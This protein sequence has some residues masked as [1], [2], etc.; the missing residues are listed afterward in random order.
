MYGKLYFENNMQNQMY[1][2]NPTNEYY[3]YIKH[4]ESVNQ[5]RNYSCEASFAILYLFLLFKIV[6]FG[7][8]AINYTN[9]WDFINK[10]NIKIYPKKNNNTNVKQSE[11]DESEGRESDGRESEGEESEGEESEGR[12]SEGEESEGGESEGEE[13]EG[14]ESEGGESEGKESEGEESEESKS[15]QYRK[16]NLD[17]IEK[18]DKLYDDNTYSLYDFHPGTRK[19]IY[20]RNLNRCH[21]YMRRGM[22]VARGIRDFKSMNIKLEGN[23]RFDYDRFKYNQFKNLDQTNDFKLKEFPTFEKVGT[24]LDRS[25]IDQIPNQSVPNFFK[26][27]QDIDFTKYINDNVKYNDDCCSNN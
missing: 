24:D 4:Q 10:N 9:V 14:R 22:R 11:G 8:L 2:Y 12:E 26:F 15:K 18:K 21:P 23:T 16:N 17:N 7:L 6:E 5:F 1:V 27:G 19:Q 13:S 3:S 20:T 25:G